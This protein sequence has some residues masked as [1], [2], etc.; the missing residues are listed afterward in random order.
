MYTPN[1]LLLSSLDQERWWP[2][3]YLPVPMPPQPLRLIQKINKHIEQYKVG[4]N[5]HPVASCGGRCSK[6]YLQN[7]NLSTLKNQTVLN[8]DPP[9]HANIP[10][11]SRDASINLLLHH[12][13]SLFRLVHSPV[14]TAG[15]EWKRRHLDPGN[16]STHTKSSLSSP[17]R[18]GILSMTQS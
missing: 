6:E 5:T 18:P 17:H 7:N 2:Q 14:R 1:Y 9:C 3:C 13:M 16:R 15:R 8:G 4:G 12:F 10:H 11:V